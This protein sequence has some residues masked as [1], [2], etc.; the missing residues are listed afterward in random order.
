MAY[1]GTDYCGWQVQINGITIQEVMMKAA[2]DL[3][4][5]DVTITGA[6]RTDAGVHAEGQVVLLVGEKKIETYKLPLALNG[7]LPKSIVVM[8]AKE[9]SEDFHPRYTNHI[10]TYHYLICHKAHHLPNMQRYS[11]HYRHNLD[12]DKMKEAATYLIGKHDFTSFASKGG[13]AIDKIRTIFQIDIQEVDSIVVIKITGNGFLYNMVRIIVG[14]LLEVGNGKRSVISVEESL[15]LKERGT[16]GPTA[17]AKGL[18]LKSIN[19]ID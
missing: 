2:I 3:F 4:G 11:L 9:V 12:I 16:A 14:T 1:D 8:N 5:E 19:Y 13:K 15:K 18:T 7:R 6:S 17:L 10:K